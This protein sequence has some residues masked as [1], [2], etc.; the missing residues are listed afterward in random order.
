[1]KNNGGWVIDKNNPQEIYKLLYSLSENTDSY[2]TCKEAILNINFKSTY[3]MSQEYIY[4]YNILD[5]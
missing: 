2:L 5:K 4:L 1:M 3:E